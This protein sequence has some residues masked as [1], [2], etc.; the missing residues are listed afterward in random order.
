MS[1]QTTAVPHTI[2]SGQEPDASP[3]Q[4]EIILPEQFFAEL[5]GRARGERLLLIAILEDAIHCFQKFLFATRPREQ[6]LFREAERWMMEMGWRNPGED[7]APHFSFE[8][9]C[10]V[11]GIDPD[12][13]RGRLEHWRQLASVRQPVFRLASRSPHRSAPRA[14]GRARR[15]LPGLRVA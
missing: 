6:R 2:E 13:L 10:D 15:E 5:R 12:Y 8:Q 9:V 4:P 14:K 11:L 7:A 3:L 1:D